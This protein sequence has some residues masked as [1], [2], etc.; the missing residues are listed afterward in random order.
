[1]AELFSMKNIKSAIRRRITDFFQFNLRNSSPQRRK[2]RKG[3]SF[4]AFRRKAGKLKKLI[5]AYYSDSIT[6]RTASSLIKE[7]SL[8]LRPL[9]LCGELLLI[10]Q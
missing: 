8:S 3:L 9:R 6:I 7:K 10:C 4:S 2:E 5:L 1:M